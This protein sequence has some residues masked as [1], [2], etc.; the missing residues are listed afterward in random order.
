[1]QLTPP[2]VRDTPDAPKQAAERLQKMGP[3]SRDET[4]ML[5][6]MGFAVVL[7]VTGDAI[8]VSSVVAAMLGKLIR[9]SGLVA[10][11]CC[12]C[13]AVVTPAAPASAACGLYCC[14]VG[15]RLCN[16]HQFCCSCNAG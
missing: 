14:A 8:G 16:W 11:G 3:M 2:E 15:H 6:T 9:P 13:A 1:M 4:I 5:A 12:A 7:W 10:R